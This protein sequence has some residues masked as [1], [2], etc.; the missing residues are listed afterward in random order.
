MTPSIPITGSRLL[1]LAAIGAALAGCQTADRVITGTTAPTDYRD[2]HPIVLQ[3]G[4]SHLDV[5]VGRG[6]RTVDERQMAD[7]RAFAAEYR[8]RGRGG[9]HVQ[10]PHGHP[11]EPYARHA[12]GIVRNALAGSGSVYV[13]HYRPGDPSLAA[14]VRLTFSTLQAKVDS[15]CG[16]WPDDLGTGPSL[17]SGRN[18]PFHNLGCASQQ[19]MAAQIADP[20]DLVRPRPEGRIDTIKRTRGIEAIRQAKDPSTQYNDKATQINQGVGSR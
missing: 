5:F 4:A 18:E 11:D 16:L 7:I 12:A 14:P 19:N 1:L 15:R 10:V 13:T 20:L 6:V 17:T 9:I 8:S 2:R 3:Q